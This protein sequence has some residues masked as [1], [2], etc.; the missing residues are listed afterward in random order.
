MC[1]ETN[2]IFVGAFFGQE[3][4][5]KCM[6]WKLLKKVTSDF[7]YQEI[8][9]GKPK[10]PT[11]DYLTEDIK[12][13]IQ[14]FCEPWKKKLGKKVNMKT[15]SADPG[16]FVPFLLS[17]NAE[18][19]RE[20]DDHKSFDVRRRPL[21]KLLSLLPKVSVHWRFIT[22][23]VNALSSFVKRSLPRNYQSQL[24][25]FFHV[26][27]FKKLRYK[28]QQSG[29]GAS[30][31]KLDRTLDD[32]SLDEVDNTYLPI[33]L[34]PGRKSVFIAAI[35]LEYNRQVRRCTTS[36]YY[37]MAG[38][39]KY[40]KKLNSMKAVTGIDLVESQ[41]P[42]SKTSRLGVYEAFTSYMLNNLDALFSFYGHETAKDRFTLY[43][44]RQRAPETM[45]N[46]PPR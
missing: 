4:Q 24:E 35:G 41:I 21:P 29:H 33:T 17:L 37:H 22:L 44:G 31:Q 43:Q 5:K 39:T 7:C 30:F 9:Q 16:S 10:W 2:K 6:P 8:C 15:L 23:S 28:R 34:D 42:S 12:A 45:A 26:F 11:D 32:F 27:D 14:T 20:H 36:E 46:I 19:E 3:F 18:F 1:S 38:S 40:C 25:L 13:K